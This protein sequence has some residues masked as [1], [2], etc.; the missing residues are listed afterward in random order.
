MVENEI[1]RDCSPPIF[2]NSCSISGENGSREF[3]ARSAPS[4]VLACSSM[5]RS[6]F[7]P[8]EPMAVNAAMPSTMEQENRRSRFRLVRLSRQA[9]FHV[10]AASRWRRKPRGGFMRPFPLLGEENLPTKFARSTPGPGRDGALRRL[11]RGAAQ[12][13]REIA[14]SRIVLDVSR[15]LPH[16]LQSVPPRRTR[17]GD[18]AARCPY[19]ES[20]PSS[21][22]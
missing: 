20:G 15:I 8:R 16:P 7:V 14:Q 12:V 19:Q 17:G 5:A 2:W 13:R 1:S 10:H 4:K 6:R 21:H 9:I 11:R 18:I 3:S 22:Q